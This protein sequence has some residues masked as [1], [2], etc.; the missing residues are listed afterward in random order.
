M[1]NPMKGTGDQTHGKFNFKCSDVGPKNCDWQASGNSEDE[2]MQKA[3][4]H[5]RDVHNIPFDQNIK[6][7]VH[8]AIQRQAA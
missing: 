4:R 8:N 7:Q 3:E 6:D 1:D 2:V 5:G